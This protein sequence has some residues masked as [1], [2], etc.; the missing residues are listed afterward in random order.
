[1]G[2]A[3]E[4]FNGQMEILKNIYTKAFIRNFLLDSSFNERLRPRSLRD[5][6][7]AAGEKH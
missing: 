2:I 7:G 5:V 6:G 1:M 4:T 3:I